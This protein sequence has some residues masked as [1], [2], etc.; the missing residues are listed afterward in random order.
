MTRV[1]TELPGKIRAA[2]SLTERNNILFE[3]SK[4]NKSLLKNIE[5]KGLFI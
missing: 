3:F 5:E 4:V 1:L 2:A